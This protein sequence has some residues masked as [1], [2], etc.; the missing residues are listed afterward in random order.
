MTDFQPGLNGTNVSVQMTGP[1]YSAI[2]SAHNDSA[3]AHTVHV[4]ATPMPVP[5]NVT[6][7]SAS[8]P[9]TVSASPA[10]GPKRKHTQKSTQAT[11]EEAARNAAEEDKRRRNTAA[12]AR[13]RVKKKMREQALERTV[14]ETTEKNDALQARVSQLELENHWLRGLIMEKNGTEEHSEASEQAISN[15]FKNFLAS[16]KA[17]SSPSL[18]KRGVG[19]SA[20]ST[21][22]GI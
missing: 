13:F 22:I 1:S 7:V 5:H 15:M 2:P 8:T 9:G 6:S 10:P 11:A 4:P 18:S 12:S 3:V 19:T 14:K 17:E 20:L 21:Q 16:R